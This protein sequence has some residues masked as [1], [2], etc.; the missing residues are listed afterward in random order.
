MP[1]WSYT[2]RYDGALAVEAMSEKKNPVVGWVEKTMIPATFYEYVTTNLP[3]ATFVDA[4]DWIDE[5]RV[6]K[7]AEEIE[8]IRQT[9]A[10]QD[11]CFDHLKKVIQP[12]MRGYEVYAEVMYFCT[13]RAC[14]RMNCMVSS[15]PLG[16]PVGPTV[17]HLGGRQI[18]EGDQVL[19]LVEGNGPGGQWTELA[20]TFVVKAEPTPALR[21]AFAHSVEGQEVVT[22]HM[23]PGACARDIVKIAQEFRAG[24]GYDPELFDLAHGMGYS[25]VERPCF[26]PEEPMKLKANS[27]VAVHVGIDRSRGRRRGV[28]D[29]L[30]QLPD[31]SGERRGAASQVSEGA[32]SHLSVPTESSDIGGLVTDHARA[33]ATFHRV[34][35]PFHLGRGR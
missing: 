14:S 9:A 20:R 19:V 29:V 10:M 15:A 11:A 13:K 28:R 6:P 3:G 22:R 21:D 24:H 35:I 26:V 17:F 8:M 5:L 30:R 4:T 23:V 25:M 18:K 7:S 33:A 34:A 31:R 27:N 12:G 32:D 1:T 2:K 16:T